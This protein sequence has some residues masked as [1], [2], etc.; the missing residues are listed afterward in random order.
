M[1]LFVFLTVTVS[2]LAPHLPAP[3]L[4]Y[5]EQI[6]QRFGFSLRIVKPRRTRLGDFRVYPDG[7]QQIT[8]NADLNPYAFLI[9]YVHE[10]AHA[11]VYQAQRN[12]GRRY[13]QTRPHGIAWQQAFRELMQPLLNESIFPAAILQ[14]LLVY[15]QQPTATTAG[16]PALIAAL[17]EAAPPRL[18]LPGQLPLADLVEGQAFLFQKK[19][20]VRGALRRTRVVCKETASGRLY[21]ILAQAQVIIHD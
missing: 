3:A 9:T 19:I 15:L 7:H 13:R 18:D 12:A 6:H 1:G 20:F 17:R 8:V 16:C 10:V 2:L 14:P 4:C 11:A 5:A 21:A